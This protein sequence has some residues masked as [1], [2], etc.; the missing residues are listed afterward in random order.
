MLEWLRI[1]FKNNDKKKAKKVFA[2][3]A[4]KK[5]LNQIKDKKIKKFAKMQ[6]IFR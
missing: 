5:M 3:D 4:S 2:I 6:R 1:L